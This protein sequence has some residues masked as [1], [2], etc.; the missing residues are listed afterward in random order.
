[1]TPR[2]DIPE[3]RLLCTVAEACHLLSVGK[4]TLYSMLSNQEIPSVKIGR[5]R[6]IPVSAL[7]EL[8]QRSAY[9]EHCEEPE[10]STN[11]EGNAH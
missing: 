9:S 3:R 4:T 11:T 5:S 8:S 2:H 6:R 1:M 7:T 10:S